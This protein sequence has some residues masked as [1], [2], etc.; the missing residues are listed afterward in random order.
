MFDKSEVSKVISSFE[1]E[2]DT[3]LPVELRHQIS[4]S[5]QG[6]PWLLKKLCIHLYENIESGAGTDSTVLELDVASLFQNDV[7][8]LSPGELAC[9]KLIAKKSPADWGE[10]IEASGISNVNSLVGKRMVVKSGDRLNVYWDI[11]RDYLLTG[12]TPV[13]PFNYVPSVDI[14]TLQKVAKHLEK[15]KYQTSSA[16][17]EK[18]ELQLRTIWNV[19]ADLV[20]FGVAERRGTD[21]QLHRDI[22]TST[23][24]DV[25]SRVRSKLGKHSLKINLYNKYS[26]QVVDTEIIGQELRRCLP[27]AI[28]NDKTW[29]AYTNRFISFLQT[30]GFISPVSAGFVVKDTGTINPKPPRRRGRAFLPTSTPAVVSETLRKIIETSALSEINGKGVRDAINT[31]RRFD[32]IKTSD[33]TVTWNEFAITKAGSEEASIWTA[34]S[35]EA[36]IK[37]CVDFL[38][39]NPSATGTEIGEYISVE[40]GFDWQSASKVRYGNSLRQW[41]RWIIEGSASPEIPSPP[42]RTYST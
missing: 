7:D 4:Y 16:L 21:F 30:C 23:E 15:G 42:G 14:S 2:A 25:L 1:K 35:N 8:S 27:D 31:L 11:F 3:K 20:L 37:K 34:A 9:L 10:I 24:A 22:S 41:S 5:C 13:V 18:S 6:F 39:R 19:G 38:T 26:G 32:L 17:A 12:V 28:Y 29:R 36:S 40:F 33:G